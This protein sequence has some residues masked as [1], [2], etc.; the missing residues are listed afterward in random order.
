MDKE[1]KEKEE[2]RE[3]E[4]EKDKFTSS[5]RNSKELA[6]YFGIDPKTFKKWLKIANLDL[7]PRLGYYFSPRQVRLI[8]DHMGARI[9]AFCIAVLEFLTEGGFSG[10]DP[11]HKHDHDLDLYDDVP[12]E[13]A[14]VLPP[15]R[16]WD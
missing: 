1:K 14:H 10:R 6:N 2:E 8:V 9:I 13:D 12:D 3:E 11:D 4:K 5:P 15:L 16:R 7:G